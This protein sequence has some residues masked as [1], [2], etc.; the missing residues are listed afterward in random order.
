[1]DGKLAWISTTVNRVLFESAPQDYA[2]IVV[3]LVSGACGC[4]ARR[5][6]SLL[7]K[8]GFAKKPGFSLSDIIPP[9]RR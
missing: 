3:Q 8:P 9:K 4:A 7:Q 2:G 6:G 1:V 5:A